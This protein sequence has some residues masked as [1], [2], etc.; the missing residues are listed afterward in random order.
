MLYIREF[1]MVHIS[2]THLN[3]LLAKKENPLTLWES[4]VGLV[5]G[6]VIIKDSEIVQV[7]IFVPTQPSQT[8]QGGKEVGAWL[9]EWSKDSEIV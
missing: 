4:C 7:H 3:P 2:H 1:I 6:V 9:K 5:K 8:A